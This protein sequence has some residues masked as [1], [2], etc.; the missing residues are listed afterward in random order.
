MRS[1]AVKLFY[2]LLKLTGGRPFRSFY[3]GKVQILMFHRIVSEF[4]ENR[5]DNDGIEISER[6]LDY[7][8][9]FYMEQ[10][11]I[12]LSINDVET[13]LHTKGRKRYVVFTF[14]DGYY[15]NYEKALPIFEKHHIPFAVYVP[16]DFINRKQF[17]W[18]Y[19]IEDVIRNNNSLAYVHNGS[20]KTVMI[21]TRQE[22]AAFFIELR[23]MIQSDAATLPALIER[24]KPDMASYHKLFLDTEQLI[25][26]SKHPLVTI[27]SHS[28]SHPS[29]ARMSDDVSYKE[30]YD[31]K[32]ELENIIGK[33]VD[34]FSYPFG[35]VNDVSE[36]ELNNARKAGYL[37]ALTTSYGDVH[38][39]SNLFR[40]PRIWTS[41]HNK[42]TELL[43]SIFG[44]NAFHLR[45][46]KEDNR[47]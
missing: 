12:P 13:V 16:T 26:L 31:S 19:F 22:K 47:I 5:I 43:K 18:W 9:R 36:R 27:G 23:K 14:D 24:Y 42:E 34:H 6:Y 37:T 10:G 1:Q 20:E 17:A 25:L 44:I 30:M 8:I 46:K 15:D 32:K 40:L 21:G 38:L 39:N 28:V 7:L 45:H 3:S 41:E 29:L 35:T 33:K 2:Q 11:F 4:G